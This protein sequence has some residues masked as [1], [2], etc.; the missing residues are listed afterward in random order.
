MEAVGMPKLGLQMTCGLITEW[1]VKEGDFVNKGD[2]I[3]AVETD[4]LAS[5]VESTATGTVLKI[6][7]QAGDEAEVMEPCCYVGEKEEDAATEKKA[8]EKAEKNG[9][10]V[11]ITPAAKRLAQELNIDISSIAGTGPDGRIQKED[12]LAA[13]EKAE[14]NTVSAAPEPEAVKA[15]QGLED[16]EPGRTKALSSMRRVIAE[17]LSES[18]K[19]IP[20][21]YMDIEVN[22]SSMVR[23]RNLFK[24]VS[25]RKNGTKLTYNDIVVKAAATAVS[26]FQE[27]NSRLEGQELRYFDHVNIGVAV[28][29]PN[30]LLVPVIRN[31]EE[32]SVS[33]ISKTIAE[34]AGKARE[35]KL[36]P[37]DITGGTFTVSNIGNVGI[38]GFHAIINPPEIGILAV[39]SIIEKAVVVEHELTVQPM[40]KISGS[41]DHRVIDGA[42]AAK[43]MVRLKELLEDAFSLFY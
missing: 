22:A 33:E 19:Q 7:V 25:V 43:F 2:P 5:D 8:E 35:G 12:I 6:V 18:K 14:A 21:I 34:L 13:S 41:F 20:H 9:E 17:R 11:R 1:Y 27:M 31:A 16:E 38:D 32:K 24:D 36:L 3:F 26:E 30:G 23:A 37:D 42:Y 39:A 28:S 40:L 4:K 15:S 29:V 10:R